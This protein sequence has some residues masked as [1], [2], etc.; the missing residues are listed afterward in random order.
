MSVVLTT[1]PTANA[2]SQGGGAPPGGQRTG[3]GTFA[4]VERGCGTRIQGD[5]YLEFVLDQGD[6]L[7][8]HLIEQSAPINPRALGIAPVGITFFERG[9]VMHI[10]DW[11]GESNYMNVADIL[12]E[13][14]R[15]GGSRKIAKKELL[16]DAFLRLDHR[17]EIFLLHPRAFIHNAG[18]Y[19]AARDQT[20]PDD[21]WCPKRKAEHHRTANRQMCA[22]LWWEDIEGG[23]LVPD[24][25]DPRLV[26]RTNGSTT[27]LGFSPPAD[28]APK[29]SPA[30]IARFKIRNLAVVK[31]LQDE[32]TEAIV[33][34]ARRGRLPVRVATH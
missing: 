11:V 31:G 7:D 17:S 30:F 33:K 12:E 2:L 3:S 13:I 23:T 21:W 8:D 26:S 19:L 29:R 6:L 32:L 20:A 14:V 1:T 22:S 18:A 28:V 10:A 34:Q 16:T 9:G 24:E 27:Y 4:A 15:Y 25:G 5:V